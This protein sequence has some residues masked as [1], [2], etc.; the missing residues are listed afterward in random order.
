MIVES[1]QSLVNRRLGEYLRES[2]IDFVCWS[3]SQCKRSEKTSTFVQ[4]ALTPLEKKVA[5]GIGQLD[6][7]NRRL[8]SFRD[9][10]IP[11][12]T[13]VLTLSD[14]NITSFEGFVPS[15][16]L[17]TLILDGNPLLSFL[18]FPQLHSIRPFSAKHRKTKS[19]VGSPH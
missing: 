7:S 6:F 19:R 12:V 17:E 9:F 10:E 1:A 3:L 15:P 14:N 11:V 4:T 8:T 16:R 2:S 18:G 13:Q 5:G